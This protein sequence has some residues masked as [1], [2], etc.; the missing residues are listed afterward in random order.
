[1]QKFPRNKSF[2]KSLRL[3]NMLNGR[4]FFEGLKSACSDLNCIIDVSWYLKSAKVRTKLMSSENYGS[5]VYVNIDSLAFL[6]L[7]KCPVKDQRTRG[8]VFTC[9]STD[10]SPAQGNGQSLNMKW[11]SLN[12]C[13]LSPNTTF[14]KSIFKLIPKAL[15]IF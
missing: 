10:P 1:M 2:L 9:T 7:V 12:S 5:L 3:I 4:E 14:I 13:S 15:C 6:S 11:K 8:R